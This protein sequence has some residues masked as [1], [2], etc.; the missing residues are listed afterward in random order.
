MQVKQMRL[1]IELGLVAALVSFVEPLLKDKIVRSCYTQKSVKTVQE[2]QW[3]REVLVNGRILKIVCCCDPVIHILCSLQILT[4]I[5]I[6]D[7]SPPQ[8][9]YGLMR[10]AERGCCIFA[11]VQ[12]CVK[13]LKCQCIYNSTSIR[14]NISMQVASNKSQVHFGKLQLAPIRVI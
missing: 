4:G 12:T 1:N 3:S 6:W 9:F 2:V 11:T 13:S 8:I 10:Y 7:E 14:Y 5:W